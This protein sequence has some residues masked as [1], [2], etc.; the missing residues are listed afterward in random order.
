MEVEKWARGCLILGKTGLEFLNGVGKGVE[1]HI[2]ELEEAGRVIFNGI[3][4]RREIYSRLFLLRSMA[5]ASSSVMGL[6]PGSWATTMLRPSPL[7][8]L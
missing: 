4:G 2:A 3:R 1:T 8:P 7:L 5:A 6:E